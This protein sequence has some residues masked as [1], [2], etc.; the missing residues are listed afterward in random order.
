MRRY[1][2]VFVKHPLRSFENFNKLIFI[3]VFLKARA[4]GARPVG[5]KEAKINLK[6]LKVSSPKQG[7]YA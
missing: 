2:I 1:K 5:I 3:L 7:L 4:C 6:F